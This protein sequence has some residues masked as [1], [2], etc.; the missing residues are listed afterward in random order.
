SIEESPQYEYSGC[1]SNQLARRGAMSFFSNRRQPDAEDERRDVEP[2]RPVIPQHPIGFETVLGASSKLEGHFISEGNVRLDGEFSGTLDIHGNVLVGET[3]KIN[4]NI[5]ARNI[6]IAGS[7]RG[8]VTGNKVQLLRTG[9]IWGDIT[10]SAL[11][12]E[13]GAFIDGKITMT[14]HPINRP[15]EETQAEVAE[16]AP[17]VEEPLAEAIIAAELDEDTEILPVNE[18]EETEAEDTPGDTTTE[19]E[20]HD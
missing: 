11:T 18:E 6:S 4:A 8:N 20:P 10:A 19:E 7:V 1:Q 5:D 14:G 13:E 16:E 17:E 12:T 9:R 2:Q 3:A 15:E